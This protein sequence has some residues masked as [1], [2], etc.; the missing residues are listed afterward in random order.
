M[1]LLKSLLIA[2]TALAAAACARAYAPPGG[3]RDT[4]PPRLM[5][6]VP[7]PLATVPAGFD[8]PVVF[9]FDERIS[10]R[11]FSE[12]LVLV[13]PLDGALR[14]ERGRREVR[15]RIDGGWRPERVYRV[16]L[17]PG[18]RD[19]F[20]NARQ[21]PAEIVFSTGPPVPNTA[22][23]GIVM[24][25]VTGRAAQN[26][27]INA[28]RRGDEVVYTAVTDTAGF[29][30]LR[31]MPTGVYDMMAYADL[32]RN[33][34]RDA[35]EPV[36]SGRV[37][38]LAAQNDTVTIVFQVLAPDTTPPRLTRAEQVDSLRVR[39]AF[40]DYMEG[41]VAMEGAAAEVYALPDTVS[42]GAALRV[43]PAP[44]FERERGAARSQPADTVPADTVPA[45][46]PR[47]P[48]EQRPLLPTRE[49]VVE[50][51]RP[52]EPGREYLIIITG[53]V[54]IHGLPGGGEAAF[55]TRAAAPVREAVP[56]PPDTMM[57]R[58]R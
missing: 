56:P 26:A 31:H 46:A 42:H 50:L 41:D 45:P 57:V 52:L 27:V 23:A 12:A 22:V 39:L 43:L 48:A 2:T 5:E 53:V 54:N 33:R 29:F 21:E 10:E 37:A 30:S 35:P 9:R 7:G 25:R 49:L 3:E 55:A 19:L 34:R 4:Q 13:S 17:L 20:G 32:N 14:V 36:D 6:T 44:L 47:R 40:D 18:V 8:E 15:V 28:V 51:T 38:S 24:D 16:V 58:P 1:H 11:N